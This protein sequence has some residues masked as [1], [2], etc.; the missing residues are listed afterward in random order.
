MSGGVQSRWLTGIAVEQPIDE[1]NR[2]SVS[3]R[4][5]VWDRLGSGD[6]QPFA[7]WRA[8]VGVARKYLPAAREDFAS[9]GRRLGFRINETV[10]LDLRDWCPDLG[11]CP[12]RRG[13]AR[14]RSAAGPG[15]QR[16][17][18]GHRLVAGGSARPVRRRLVESVSPVCTPP[19][20]RVPERFTDVR[21]GDVRARWVRATLTEVKRGDR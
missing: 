7:G 4:G 13:F 19:L 18:R 1:F 14:L 21:L 8:S 12:L 16:R 3:S 17:G 2:Q 9:S 10:M 20:G 6:R 15:E 5:K 11:P